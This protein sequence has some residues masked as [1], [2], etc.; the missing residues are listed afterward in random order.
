MKFAPGAFKTFKFFNNKF[1]LQVYYP[2]LGLFW[3]KDLYQFYLRLDCSFRTV[4]YA[5]EKVFQAGFVIFGVGFG[6]SIGNN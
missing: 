1:W 6:V 3:T 2:E 4:Y 5:K